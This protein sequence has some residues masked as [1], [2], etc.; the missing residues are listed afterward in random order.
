MANSA[1][2]YGLYLGMWRTDR[3]PG[4]IMSSFAVMPA[5]RTSSG[6]GAEASSPQQRRISRQRSGYRAESNAGE[7][8]AG[9]HQRL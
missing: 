5:H 3:R 1:D 4:T 6:T 2:H 8:I 9:V 7:L